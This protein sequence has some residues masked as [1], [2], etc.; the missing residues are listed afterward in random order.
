MSCASYTE[1]KESQLGQ[2][3]PQL[4]VNW[5]IVLKLQIIA[6]ALNQLSPQRANLVLLSAANEGQ[7]HLKERWF[8][9]Q[10]SVEGKAAAET[11]R[12]PGSCNRTA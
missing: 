1:I 3:E 12:V 2:A 7:C 9:T 6:D 10:Y 5:S 4:H 8:G 11:W